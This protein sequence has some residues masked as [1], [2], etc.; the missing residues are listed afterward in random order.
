[1]DAAMRD[2]D[3]QFTPSGRKSKAGSAFS[4]AEVEEH[5]FRSN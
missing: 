2:L 3:A 1:M 5:R 4:E